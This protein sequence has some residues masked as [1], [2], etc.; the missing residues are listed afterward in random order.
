M[1]LQ[2]FSELNQTFASIN[3]VSLSCKPVMYI[4]LDSVLEKNNPYEK[5]PSAPC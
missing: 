3:C 2:L 1:N 4:Y 5:M